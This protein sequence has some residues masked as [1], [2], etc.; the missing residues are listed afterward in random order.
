MRRKKKANI[1][2]FPICSHKHPESHSLDTA[3]DDL[4]ETKVWTSIGS[5]KKLTQESHK[6]LR[7]FNSSYVYSNQQCKRLKDFFQF[8]NIVSIFSHMKRNKLKIT[9]NIQ[10]QPHLLSLI[11]TVDKTPTSLSVGENCLL[12]TLN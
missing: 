2:L 8:I 7:S 9:K 10:S 1:G 12:F 11:Y 6:H 5:S 3:K 4:F